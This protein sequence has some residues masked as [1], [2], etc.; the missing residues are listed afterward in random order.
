MILGEVR[1]CQI[2]LRLVTTSRPFMPLFPFVSSIGSILS[3]TFSPVLS[4]RYLKALIQ[5][6]G[7]KVPLFHNRKPY[8]RSVFLCTNIYII[9][10]RFSR[11]RQIEKNFAVFP[12]NSSFW[13]RH[14]LCFISVSCVIVL[15]V[16]ATCLTVYGSV[17]RGNRKGLQKNILY[18]Y[19]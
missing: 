7:K 8:K 17:I 1:E 10:K 9:D 6:I 5:T 16:I 14:P 19:H 15:V 4:L 13:F 11:E 18:S 12:N 2:I 3:N